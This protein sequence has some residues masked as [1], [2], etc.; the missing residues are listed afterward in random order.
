MGNGVNL[1]ETLIITLGALIAVFSILVLY[2]I[3]ILSKLSQITKEVKSESSVEQKPESNF[4]NS[5][6]VVEYDPVQIV[7]D[8]SDEEDRLV[9]ALAAS[10]MASN[11]K[12]DSYFHISKLTRIK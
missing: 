10:I 3:S 9:V 8:S 4:I 12:P 11:E 6:N 7:N 1:S 2:A 5:S